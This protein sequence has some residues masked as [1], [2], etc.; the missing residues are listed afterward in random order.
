MGCF[1]SKDAN[2]TNEIPPPKKENKE[3]ERVYKGRKPQ[4]D[5]WIQGTRKL[6]VEGDRVNINPPPGREAVPKPSLSN[7]PP[8]G[9]LPSNSQVPNKQSS[10]REV[11]IDHARNNLKEIVK[12]K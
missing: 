9:P 2:T 6:S 7:L 1:K 3:K 12:M 8:S 10:Q 4:D 5:S 11:K